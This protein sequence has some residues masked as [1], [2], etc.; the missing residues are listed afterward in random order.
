M[1][2]RQPQG[3]AGIRFTLTNAL[4]FEDIDRLLETVAA[5]YPRC[6]EVA[7]QT[8]DAAE[9]AFVK[10]RQRLNYSTLPAPRIEAE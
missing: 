9:Q 8:P 1:Y 5:L 3:R 4:R 6:L 2:K 7:G 10:V